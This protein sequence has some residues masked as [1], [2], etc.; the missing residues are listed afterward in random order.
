M[1]DDLIDERLREAFREQRWRDG[2]STPPFER[3]AHPRARRARGTSPWLRLAFAVTVIVVVIFVAT[4]HRQSQPATATI[5]LPARGT[6]IT[7]WRP[8]TDALLR[9]PGSEILETVP[10]I[11]DSVIPTARLAPRLPQPKSSNDRSSS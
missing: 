2:A 7:S 8:V 4:L 10:V 5:D 11:S 1:R 9:T 3:L 6:P